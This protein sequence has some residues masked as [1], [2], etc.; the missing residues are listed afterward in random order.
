MS[1][2]RSEPSLPYRQHGAALVVAMFVFAICTAVIVAMKGE[3]NRFF[4]RNANQLWLAQSEAYLRGA[5]ELASVVLIADY[6]KDKE[7]QNPRDHLT[8][9]WA[10]DDAPPFAIDDSAWMRGAVE[11][12]QGRFNLN[13]LAQAPQG[14]DDRRPRRTVHQEM[15]IRLLQTLGEEVEV[16][17][18][19]A[20][21]IADS[22]SDWVDDNQDPLADGAE[23]QHYFSLTP[24]Y[25]VPNMPMASVSELRA[26]SNM[27]PEIYA[28]LAPLVTV[29]PR[30][31]G[32]I[33]VNTAPVQV[34]RTLNEEGVLAPMSEADG[35]TLLDLRGDA[36]YADM[37]TFRQASVFAGREAKM[38]PAFAQ[39]TETSSWFLLRA[40]VQLADRNR[41]MYSVL[42]RDKRSIS[43]MARAAGSL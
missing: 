40:E 31:P 32:R 6:D 19:E 37:A 10:R 34:L 39:L 33:N 18:F 24:S 21:A 3:F 20:I 14:E 43:T 4:Q 38:A 15:F 36:G 25:R 35:Q 26:V 1:C 7:D 41:Q 9:D 30:Q 22:V 29:W 11:D 12:L 17:E 5:E 13:W 8:E 42:W 23:D 27:T 16:S 28:A 2:R